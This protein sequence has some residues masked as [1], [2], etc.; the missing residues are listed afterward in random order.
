MNIKHDPPRAFTKALLVRDW[1]QISTDPVPITPCKYVNKCC[2]LINSFYLDQQHL[3]TL[4]RK[5]IFRTYEIVEIMNEDLVNLL[6][7]L[8]EISVHMNQGG[9]HPRYQ[10]KLIKARKKID[11][12]L[13]KVREYA[14]ESI[15]AELALDTISFS[16]YAPAYGFLYGPMPESET[17]RAKHIEVNVE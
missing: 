4:A 12:L 7:L 10:K 13:G 1:R 5:N 11:E 8:Q 14:K 6:F 17:A 15:T 16:D 2:Y 9:F 3:L